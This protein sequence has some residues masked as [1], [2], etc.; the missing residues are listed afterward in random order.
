VSPA[1]LEKLRERHPRVAFQLLPNMPF[2]QPRAEAQMPPESGEMRLVFQGGLRVASGLPELFRA[3]TARPQFSLDVFGAGAEENNLKAAAK[4][5]GLG[6][7]VRFRGSVPFETLPEH[8]ARAHCG[9]HLMQPVCGS[10]ALTWANKIF[11]YAHSLLPMLLSDNPAHR[12]LLREFRVGVAVDSFSSEAVGQGL[13]A[14]A[15]GYADFREQCRKAK[16]AWHW[17]ARA[18]ELPAFLGL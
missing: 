14:L 16:E 10:F 18:G 13:E 1:I 2:R 3:L 7:R 4:R 9:I 17:E 5:E 15:A 6:D 12:A 8:L 11:D